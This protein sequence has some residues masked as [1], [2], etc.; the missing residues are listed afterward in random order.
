[1]T[2]SS[3]LRCWDRLI[4]HSYVLNIRGDSYRLGEKRKAGLFPSP[5]HLGT[6]LIESLSNNMLGQLSIAIAGSIPTWYL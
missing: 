6:G 4:H 2:A 1:M 3:P 5:Q